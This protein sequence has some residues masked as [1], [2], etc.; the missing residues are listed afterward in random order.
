MH[1]TAKKLTERTDEFRGLTC[2]DELLDQFT[3][4]LS[5][6]YGTYHVGS[7]NRRSRYDI[8]CHIAR[9]LNFQ[10]SQLISPIQK[11]SVRD[12]RLNTDK[13]AHYGIHFNKSMDALSECIRRYQINR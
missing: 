7:T 1:C 12:I 2:V 13:L 11:E 8:T 10:P 9:E 4:I 6:P 3:N 5:L